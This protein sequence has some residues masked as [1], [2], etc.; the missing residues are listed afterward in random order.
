MSFGGRSHPPDLTLCHAGCIAKPEKNAP[1]QLK[2]VQT[3]EGG[4]S[5]GTGVERTPQGSVPLHCRSSA[6]PGHIRAACD[7][8]VPWFGDRVRVDGVCHGELA[9]TQPREEVFCGMW[10][11]GRHVADWRLS[12][13]FQGLSG[14]TIPPVGARVTM[15]REVPVLRPLQG[16]AATIEDISCTRG[17][18]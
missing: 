14:A 11:A 10:S 2:T 15:P 3:I 12:M 8:S 18:L 6:N 9:S 1:N 7:P 5:N 13:P 17:S 4:K 16:C